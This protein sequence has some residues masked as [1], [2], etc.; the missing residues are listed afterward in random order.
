MSEIIEKNK[1][2]LVKSEYGSYSFNNRK[3]AEQLNKTLTDYEHIAEQYKETD[4]KLDQI[5]RTI[6]SLQ[7]SISIIGDELERL[8]KEV[9]Q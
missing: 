6:I 2:Y 9:I 3:T 5:Q 7:M 8:H 1:H 4:Q